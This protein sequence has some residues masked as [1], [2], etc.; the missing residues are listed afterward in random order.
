MRVK[1][2]NSDFIV[3]ELSQY[4]LGEGQFTIFELKKENLGTIDAAKSLS[5]AWHIPLKWIGYAGLKDK[6]AITKQVCS[7]KNVSRE[8]V[9]NLK[10]N[11]IDLKFLGYSSAPMSI[12]M[13]KGNAFKITV[14]DIDG[15]PR[16]KK[17]FINYFG[18]QRLSTRNPDI[19]RSIV[20]GDYKKSV[21]MFLHT[22]GKD[23]SLM[24]QHL[25][26]AP[27]DYLGALRLLPMRLLKLY[28]HAYQSRL[29][30]NCAAMHVRLGEFMD[31]IPVIGFGSDISDKR[32]KMQFEE[33]GL[34]PQD[35]VLR[36]F[37]ELSQEGTERKLIIETA[38]LNIGEL[39]KDELNHGRQ[40]VQITFTLPPGCYATEVIRQL[41]SQE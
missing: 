12:G 2:V 31:N 4:T 7:A 28:V 41:F 18:E 35:F 37:P 3:D 33:E 9:E 21:S 27:N 15:L 20:L 24:K 36:S 14:R 17:K 22:D 10:L 34:T 5:K 26:H 6:R 32:V 23:S 40:K 30:N 1:Q 13:H 8:S 19:G 16:L 25:N 11:G 38:D 39:E 29:W